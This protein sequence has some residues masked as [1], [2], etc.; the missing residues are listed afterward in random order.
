MHD[1]PFSEEDYLDLYPDVKSAILRGEFKSGWEHYTEFGRSEGRLPSKMSFREYAVFYAVDKHG[2]GLEIGPSHNPIAPKSKGFNVHILDHATGPELRE[3]YK[4]HN[5]NLCNIEDVD[6]VWRGE[7]FTELIG[8]TQ[9]YDWIIASHVIEH[10]PDFI[11]FIQECGHLLKPNGILSL[12]IPDKRFCFDYFQELTS[13]GSIIDAN[14]HKRVRPSAGQVFDHFSNAVSNKGRIAW[15]ANESSEN[16][17]L[18]HDEDQSQH[19]KSQAQ[20]EGS[21][22]DVHCWRFIPES[23][24]LI[25]SDLKLL[26]Y[27]DLEIIAAFPTDGCEFYISLGKPSFKSKQSNHTINEPR[28]NAL[29]SRKLTD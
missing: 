22:I 27:V 5:V 8:H 18:L 15:S 14:L 4:N 10:V 26:G 6:F 9:Y 24:R 25:M 17:E 23:F 7:K 1:R 12:V 29:K 3:K 19:A 21:Y 2:F 20:L 13:T 11:S 28:L 16:F